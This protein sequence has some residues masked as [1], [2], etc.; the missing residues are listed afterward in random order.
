VEPHEVPLRSNGR[1]ARRANA[2]E[3]RRE[4]LGLDRGA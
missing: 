2:R 1:R 3:G 4:T